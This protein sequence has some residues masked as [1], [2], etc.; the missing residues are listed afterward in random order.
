MSWVQAPA[1][2]LF[3]FW[4]PITS[5]VTLGK[6]LNLLCLE[7]HTCLIRLLWALNET[8]CLVKHKPGQLRRHATYAVTEGSNLEGSVLCAHHLEILNRL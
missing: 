2:D 4:L 7:G 5:Y 6:L 1:V 3:K 8:I